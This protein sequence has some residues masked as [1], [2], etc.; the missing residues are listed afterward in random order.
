MKNFCKRVYS[1]SIVLLFLVPIIFISCNPGDTTHSNYLVN[2]QFSNQADDSISLE[3]FPANIKLELGKSIFIE[4]G[5]S[6]FRFIDV[7]EN[8]QSNSSVLLQVD[9]DNGS[10]T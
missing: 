4:N 5:M 7:L 9:Y 2:N 1:F 3:T 10:T 6:T 8:C